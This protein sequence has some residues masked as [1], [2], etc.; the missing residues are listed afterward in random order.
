MT[1]QTRPSERITTEVTSW[2][3]VEAGPGRRGEFAFRV[4]RRELGHLHGDHAAH[5]GFP[6]DVWDE[7]FA[8]GRIVHHPVFPGRRGPA[9]RRIESDEDVE[10]VIRLMRDNYDRIVAQHGPP[11]PV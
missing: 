1:T 10:D 7:L 9:A 11:A 2:P 3:G 4:G 8:E 6:K 5:F